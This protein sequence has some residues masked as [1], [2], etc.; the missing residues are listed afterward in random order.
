MS[1]SC[2][3]PT[4]GAVGTAPPPNFLGE[5]AAALRLG[6][7]NDAPAFVMLAPP[8]MDGRFHILGQRFSAGI[9]LPCPAAYPVADCRKPKLRITCFT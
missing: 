2:S 1:K 3:P 7:V 4:V 5:S 6:L 9:K 8:M